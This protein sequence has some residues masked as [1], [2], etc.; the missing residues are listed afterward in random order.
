[1]LDTVNVETSRS[2]AADYVA[3]VTVEDEVTSR[4]HVLSGSAV[5]C[6]EKVRCYYPS[7]LLK[8]CSDHAQRTIA[9]KKT[10]IDASTQTVAT[11]NSSDRPLLGSQTAKKSTAEAS[12]Q[13]YVVASNSNGSPSSPNTLVNTPTD[14]PSPVAA[15]ENEGQD[16]FGRENP[17]PEVQHEEEQM[18]ELHA[19]NE[20]TQTADQDLDAE[21]SQLMSNIH[22]L[23]NIVSQ[24]RTRITAAEERATAAEGR[25][26]AAEGRAAAAEGRLA[27]VA[28]RA[29][30]MGTQ[31]ERLSQDLGTQVNRAAKA[32]AESMRVR[33]RLLGMPSGSLPS[34]HETILEQDQ[35]SN[36]IG[37]AQEENSGAG[38]L[39]D[40]QGHAEDHEIGETPAEETVDFTEDGTEEV[41]AASS[42][43][44]VEEALLSAEM[45]AHQ[46][47]RDE[48][49]QLKEAIA[50]KEGRL[51]KYRRLLRENMA[52]YE[53][54]RVIQNDLETQLDHANL[55]ISELEAAIVPLQRQVED[56]ETQSARR[57]NM[58]VLQN[59]MILRGT[60][61]LK[62]FI[63]LGTKLHARVKLAEKLPKGALGRAD[64]LMRLAEQRLPIRVRGEIYVGDDL[65]EEVDNNE[66]TKP[67]VRLAIEA[68]P[69]EFSGEQNAEM[70]SGQE[71]VSDDAEIER[72]VSEFFEMRNGTVV[73][74]SN[75]A[76]IEA[77]GPAFNNFNI[78][79]VENVASLGV[80][81]AASE[82]TPNESGFTFSLG[83]PFQES[84]QQTED[85]VKRPVFAFGGT[86][87]QESRQKAKGTANIPVFQFSATPSQENR[88]EIPSVMTPSPLGFNSSQQTAVPIVSSVQAAEENSKDGA[89]E[90]DVK[91]RDNKDE[92]N[93]QK[94]AAGFMLGNHEVTR[95]T[96]A[97]SANQPDTPK[98]EGN[99]QDFKF[100]ATTPL[101]GVQ[102][103]PSPILNSNADSGNFNFASA[104]DFNFGATTTFQAGSNLYIAKPK[105]FGGEDEDEQNEGPTK[106]TKTAPIYEAATSI[107]LSSS[108]SNKKNEKS[109]KK[110]KTAPVFE[111]AA[112]VNMASPS[113]AGSED[114][115]AKKTKAASIFEAAASVILS[116]PST[117]NEAALGASSDHDP[118]EAPEALTFTSVDNLNISRT[119][120]KGEG[121][122]QEPALQNEIPRMFGAG[123]S[124][125]FSFS[126]SGV[127]P[128]FGG[129]SNGLEG[130]SKTPS[131][132]N[133]CVPGGTDKQKQASTKRA[134]KAPVFAADA[135]AKFD[136]PASGKKPNFDQFNLGI[137]GA[138]ET[139]PNAKSSVLDPGLVAANP[140]QKQKPDPKVGNEDL[141]GL[142][143]DAS[144]TA[145]R[146]D[147]NAQQA[148]D[149]ALEPSG[150]YP[151]ECENTPVAGRHINS[152]EDLGGIPR[153]L[154]GC[155]DPCDNNDSLYEIEDDYQAPAKEPAKVEH[156]GVEPAP[157]IAFAVESTQGCFNTLPAQL[158]DSSVS[159]DSSQL[160]Q[161]ASAASRG[162]P[163]SSP[164]EANEAG[165]G[166]WQDPGRTAAEIDA[167]WELECR[168]RAVS[169]LADGVIG[170]QLFREPERPVALPPLAAAATTA[171]SMQPS[172]STPAAVSNL[173]ANHG[174]CP[175]VSPEISEG[176][177]HA[178]ETA[179]MTVRN[180]N[181]HSN[182]IEVEAIEGT[183]RYAVGRMERL[184]IGPPAPPAFL[185]TFDPEVHFLSGDWI[186][187]RSSIKR[188]AVDV[189]MEVETEGESVT[190]TEEVR[191]TEV[192]SESVRQVEQEIATPSEPHVTDSAT[193][194][195]TDMRDLGQVLRARRNGRIPRVVGQ[196]ER[197][198]GREV[199]REPEDEL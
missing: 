26:T 153:G 24:E 188:C 94:G 127:A 66:D 21:F 53:E 40:A 4:H 51:E 199:A 100:G 92:E 198:A 177:A 142:S 42:T 59:D 141:E 55:S 102:A 32:E 192:L 178:L 16:R 158:P 68:P 128:N 164:T 120:A 125:Q 169:T 144:L 152:I 11:G 105:A 162:T 194:T 39:L 166:F 111:A 91:G 107:D 123:S 140:E 114:E 43:P 34:D 193:L 15:E 135:F 65:V 119:V 160:I 173:G 132:P 113:S 148:V 86:P 191:E 41:A 155:P 187:R 145:G 13:T 89:K 172:G 63:R 175:T 3:S 49:A 195:P 121:R 149:M 136:S 44:M 108:S 58:I 176:T 99:A 30:N 9:E 103:N 133:P 167:S 101:F 67:K 52:S 36:D 45:A 150:L 183:I 163:D 170:Q 48:L 57:F 83:S 37:Q 156:V 143:G 87:V 5:A 61:E 161:S 12:T 22:D 174:T 126:P 77:E 85:A 29:T 97:T 196:R 50:R 7:G 109:N 71:A 88:Q 75:V 81:T 64:G 106:K 20:D 28:G 117:E 60:K 184:D 46:Q 122:K 47:T 72:L 54:L 104:A 112:S 190:R 17:L 19:T 137:A 180:A 74:N 154:D 31:M 182:L 186:A 157:A 95:D 151:T 80:H 76:D 35:P 90:I 130:A 14:Y 2:V 18:Q 23:M 168:Q 181:G 129:F 6:G 27:V 139:Q 82:G 159:S 185:Q 116:P 62:F 70:V 118:K 33:L 179:P 115:A 124:N 56:L 73:D 165:G 93:D 10:L 78:P 79:N 197:R 38:V 96:T 1:M 147:E 84:R 138:S 25:A 146:E 110:N 131:V 134:A 8:M 171:T 98:A 189:D 69:A